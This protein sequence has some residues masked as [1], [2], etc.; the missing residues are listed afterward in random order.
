MTNLHSLK[1]HAN[2]LHLYEVFE[3]DTQLFVIMQLLSGKSMRD[4][5]KKSYNLT[6]KQKAMIVRGLLSAVQYMH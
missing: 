3:T 4:F 1:R 5:F 2:I 6:S